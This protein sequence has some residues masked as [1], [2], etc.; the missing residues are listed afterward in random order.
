[1][2][3]GI[4]LLAL[5]L[6]A[7][8]PALKADFI[9]DDSYWLGKNPVAWANQA[10]WG[11]WTSSKTAD[12]LPV[13]ATSF[14][15]QQRLWGDVPLGYHA[16]N[17]LL[18]GLVVVGLWRV[19]RQLNIPGAYL[20]AAIFT[21]HPLTVA[22]AAWVA[23][24]KNTL[25]TALALASLLT[26]L[27]F[28]KR[29]GRAWLALSIAAFA[30]ALLA[31]SA[32]IVLPVV[33]LVCAWHL[34]G[35]PARATLLSLLPFF[36]LMIAA[37]FIT[38]FY[39]HRNAMSEPVDGPANLLERLVLV[40]R[41]CWFYPAKALWPVHL[42]MVYPRW[43]VHTITAWG[44]VQA[45]AALVCAVAVFVLRRRPFVRPMAL[46]LGFYYLALAPRW[47]LSTPPSC[48]TPSWPTTGTTWLCPG[49][50]R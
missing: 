34:R 24:Q 33:L 45:T 36:L 43:A 20:A 38:V 17:L 31:K 49:L 14:Y 27:R 37:A 30:L 2:A 6:A 41:A 8:W 13:T 1:M 35:R 10:P 26:Y 32:V 23:E 29:G 42:A 16:V 7:H 21:V 4:G 5:V 25:S 22:S 18:H 47:A 39:Q 11:Y 12:Y 3:A 19:L 40:G 46:G 28:V 15:F 44:I 50:S 9:W 48:F